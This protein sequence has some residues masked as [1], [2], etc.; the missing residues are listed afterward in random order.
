MTPKSSRVSLKR[1]MPLAIALA[2]ATF[3]ADASATV[4]SDD[5]LTPA[6]ADG[7]G[8]IAWFEHPG[9]LHVWDGT[10]EVEF[11]IALAAECR[12]PPTSL[13]DG[14]GGVVLFGCDVDHASPHGNLRH[15][16]RLLDIERRTITVPAGAATLLDQFEGDSLGSVRFTGIG[17]HGLRYLG[18]TYHA[19]YITGTIDWRTGTYLLG[20]GTETSVPDLDSPTLLTTLC[21]PLHQRT[22]DKYVPNYP[23]GQPSFD[24]YLYEQPYGVYDGPRT[25]LTLERCGSTRQTVLEPWVRRRSYAVDPQLDSGFVSWFV[26][27]RTETPP[28]RSALRAYLPECDL[29][30]AWKVE[31]ASSVAHLPGQIVW[32]EP[33]R[34]S[35]MRWTVQSMPISG[36]CGRTEAIWTARIASGR[37]HRIVAATSGSIRFTDHHV[38]ATRQRTRGAHL[39]PLKLQA[40]A[41]VRIGFGA[42]LRSL[43]WQV[44]AGRWQVAAIHGTDARLRAPVVGGDRILRVDGRFRRGGR[45]LVEVPVA[46][47]LG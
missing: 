13:I 35:E 38:L 10:A 8:A 29:R 43:R 40:G 14:G 19:E 16:P 15:E 21:E 37:R 44:G 11:D 22:Y 9:L 6:R 23:F 20:D 41:D 45:V 33:S 30:L 42:A 39:A 28:T 47:P 27:D 7:K 26:G 3:V 46:P 34:S 17:A 5:A 32:S 36:M 12:T 31:P 25:A 18:G 4:L 2:L 1:L 24:R